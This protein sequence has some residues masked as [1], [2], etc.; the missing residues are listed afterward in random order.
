MLVGLDETLDNVRLRRATGVYSAGRIIDERTAPSQ[1]IGRIV[2][3]WG[4]A[5]SERSVLEPQLGLWH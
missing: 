5:A 1:I 4:M 2:W 3:G